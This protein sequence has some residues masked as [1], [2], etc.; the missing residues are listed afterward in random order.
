MKHVLLDSADGVKIDGQY[1]ATDRW[2]DLTGEHEYA[3]GINVYETNEDGDIT[4]LV[5]HISY[6]PFSYGMSDEDV[7]SGAYVQLASDEAYRLY[8]YAVPGDEIVYDRED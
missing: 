3:S 4:N 2:A 6:L 7:Q 5:D 1:R 8:P